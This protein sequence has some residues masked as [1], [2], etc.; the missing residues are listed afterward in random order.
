MAGKKPEVDRLEMITCLMEMVV[1]R[2]RIYWLRDD[3]QFE[4]TWEELKILFLELQKIIEDDG[5]LD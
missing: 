3:D 1:P 5:R 4:A 2:L